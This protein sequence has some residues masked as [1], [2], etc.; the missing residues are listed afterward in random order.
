MQTAN[1]KNIKEILVPPLTLVAM[2]G[3]YQGLSELIS[4]DIKEAATA[5]VGG[6]PA[7]VG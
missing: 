1:S 3:N 4:N 7:K 6:D 2:T 5:I